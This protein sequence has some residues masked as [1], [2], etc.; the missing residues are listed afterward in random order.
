MEHN[1]PRLA[2]PIW[3]I[4]LTTPARNRFM[5][6]T[7]ELAEFIQGWALQTELIELDFEKRL[8][9]RGRTHTFKKVEIVNI[10][11]GINSLPLVMAMND[12][13][14]RCLRRL[15][16]HRKIRW[17]LHPLVSD[18]R[19]DI[20]EYD[21]FLSVEFPRTDEELE[22]AKSTYRDQIAFECGKH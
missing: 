20:F 12:V 6:V 17:C 4:E 21:A 22:R 7:R 14:A 18:A 2:P 13:E 5:A 15:A 10:G 11:D 16:A 9:V 19:Q 8:E 3:K 1:D